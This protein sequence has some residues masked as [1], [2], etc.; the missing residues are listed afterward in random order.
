MRGSFLDLKNLPEKDKKLL[1][2]ES[3]KGTLEYKG[4]KQTSNV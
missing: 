1:F 3:I 2:G 4:S